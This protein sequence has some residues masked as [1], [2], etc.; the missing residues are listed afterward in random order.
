MTRRTTRYEFQCYDENVMP[1]VNIYREYVSDSAARAAAG[2][3]AKRNNGPVDLAYDGDEPWS[4]RY[5]TT[6]SPSDYHTTGYRH[7][8]LYV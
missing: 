5:I 6:A 1:T 3:L 8:R 7:E 2:S 4:E